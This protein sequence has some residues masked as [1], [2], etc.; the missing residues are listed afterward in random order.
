[1]RS[2]H[3]VY[4]TVFVQFYFVLFR[5][6][7]FFRLDMFPLQFVGACPMATDPMFCKT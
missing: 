1:M 2:S 4:S 6:A 5:L 3:E 7:Y